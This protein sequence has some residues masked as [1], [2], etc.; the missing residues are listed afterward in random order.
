MTGCVLK[1]LVKGVPHDREAKN[2]LRQVLHEAI[3]KAESIVVL[4]V[5][6]GFS[7]EIEVTDVSPFSRTS[8]EPYIADHVLPDGVRACFR[9]VSDPQLQLLKA[10]FSYSE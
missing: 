4:Q 9:D 6:D 7:V 10:Q 5:V 2:D 8:F 3:P 1:Y